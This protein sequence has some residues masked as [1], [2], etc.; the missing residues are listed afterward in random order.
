MS[1]LGPLCT[2][3]GN[4]WLSAGGAP[5]SSNMWTFRSVPPTHETRPDPRPSAVQK[6]P[7]TVPCY[8]LSPV[9]LILYSSRML[10]AAAIPT[11]FPAVQVQSGFEKS[12]K[13]PRDLSRSSCTKRYMYLLCIKPY[14]SSSCRQL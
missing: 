7:C 3:L 1:V 12:S 14:S 11:E 13:I 2:V 10:S 4:V 6:L 8:A 9:C 5:C